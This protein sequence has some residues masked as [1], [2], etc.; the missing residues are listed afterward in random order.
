VA[1]GVRLLEPA[2]DLAVTAALMSSYLDKPLPEDLAVWG[3][4]GLAGEVRG[5]THTDLRLGE[6]RNLGFSQCLIPKS[7]AE[8]LTTDQR[9]GCIG[10]RSLPEVLQVLFGDLP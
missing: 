10:V 3:E 4:V 7:N 1:G 9:L 8:R 5:V 6:A 2:L